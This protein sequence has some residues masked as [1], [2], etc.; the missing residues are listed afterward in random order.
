MKDSINT[1]YKKDDIVIALGESTSPILILL[2]WMGSNHRQV[3]KYQDI[4][5]EIYGLEK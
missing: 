4:Y 5:K 1:K 3:S 2:G